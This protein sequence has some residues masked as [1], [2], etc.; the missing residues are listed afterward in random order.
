MGAIFISE[1]DV[2]LWVGHRLCREKTHVSSARR[3]SRPWLL[4]IYKTGGFNGRIPPIMAIIIV[5]L[6]GG[7]LA[8]HPA[9][10]LLTSGVTG[11]SIVGNSVQLKLSLPIRVMSQRGLGF[12][13]EHAVAEH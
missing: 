10:R 5:R 11:I 2:Q 7:D 13:T 3:H 9:T 1:I 6:I 12:F 8:D 4:T